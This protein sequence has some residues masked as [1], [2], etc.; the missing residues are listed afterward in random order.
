MAYN[1]PGVYDI[2]AARIRALRSK[3]Q[4]CKNVADFG[5]RLRGNQKWE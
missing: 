5:S 1:V 4:G 2:L 3:V